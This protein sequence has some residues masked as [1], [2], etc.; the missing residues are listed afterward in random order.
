MIDLYIHRV[1]VTFCRVL[2]RQEPNFYLSI[3]SIGM[4]IDA[5][6]KLRKHFLFNLV[7]ILL[8]Y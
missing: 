4:F 5:I 6:L 7:G 8:F 1:F 3:R 2:P